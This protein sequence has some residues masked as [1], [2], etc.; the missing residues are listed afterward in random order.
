MLAVYYNKSKNTNPSHLENHDRVIQ[1]IKYIKDKL[2]STIIYNNNQIL[3]YLQENLHLG[4]KEDI[5][6]IILTQIYSEDYLN[7]VK[8]MTQSLEDGDIIE[9]DTYFSNITFNEILDNSIILY[10]VCYQIIE[11]D[12]K[13]AYCLIR[14]PSHHS[15]LNRYNGFCIVN[16][17]YLTA[18]YLHDKHNKKILILDYD[19]HHGDGTQA[20]INQHLEDDVYFVSMHCY[21]K[22]FYPGTGNVDE[23]NEKVL[24]IPMKRGTGDELYIEKFNEVKDYI[25]SKENDIIIVSNGLDAHHADP[26]G[27]MYLTNKFYVSV[28]EYLKSL[29]KQLIYILEGGY[30]PKTIGKISVDIIKEITGLSDSI[31]FE[32]LDDSDS[33]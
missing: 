27:V 13:Y 12:I 15:S 31:E 5:A 14:P 1:S 23:N 19:V 17:T 3:T 18:K 26:F 2:P 16:H 7:E 20:L 32:E 28:T 29:D 10:N 11:N 24:N 30:N 9:G 33:D 25:K 4:S 21:G 8:E 22:G 6:N